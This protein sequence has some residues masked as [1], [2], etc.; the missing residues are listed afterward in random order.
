MV[1]QFLNQLK[2]KLFEIHSIGLLVCDSSNI[3][4]R[5]R[6]E[7]ERDAMYILTLH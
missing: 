3:S 2:V 7:D 4:A 6:S 5:T 1:L